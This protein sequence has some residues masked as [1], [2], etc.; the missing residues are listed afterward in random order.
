M[1]TLAIPTKLRALVA[2][3]G[4]DNEPEAMNALRAA[5]R[6]LPRLGISFTDLAA[7]ITAE[8]EPIPFPPDEP[9][10]TPPLRGWPNGYAPNRWP[11]TPRQEG[12]HREVARRCLAADRGR[13]RPRDKE[14]LASVAARP[15]RLSI[16]ASD[17]L[18]DIAARLELR[19]AA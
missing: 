9:P 13:L 10:Q 19:D 6:E 2:L 1:S 7:A 17:W 11:F 18:A 5:R 8:P 12:H 14:F 3:M 15:S 16:R 4:S